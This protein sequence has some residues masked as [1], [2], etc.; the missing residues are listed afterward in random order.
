MRP[1]LS[2]DEL[3]RAAL[4]VGVQMRTAQKRYFRTRSQADLIA[5]KEA[6]RAF[7]HAAEVALTATPS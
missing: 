7:D 1:A 3:L 4:K 2:I 5:S 6:E